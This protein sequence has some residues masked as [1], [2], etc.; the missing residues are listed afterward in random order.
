M[1]RK[2]VSGVFYAFPLNITPLLYK[3]PMLP[4]T[5]VV[6]NTKSSQNP[7]VI[8]IDGGKPVR[9]IVTESDEVTET[10]GLVAVAVTAVSQYVV[11]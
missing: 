9:V 10:K 3:K 2:V 4:K 7:V 8:Q 6:M 5:T 11:L 1:K